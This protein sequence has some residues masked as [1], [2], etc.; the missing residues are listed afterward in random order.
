[1]TGHFPPV[2]EACRRSLAEIEA[3]PLGLSEASEAHV[4]TCR[5]CATSLSVRLT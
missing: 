3:D 4:R 2:P 1:M 5:A